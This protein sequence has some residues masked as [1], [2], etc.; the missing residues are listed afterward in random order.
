MKSLQ[1][2]LIVITLLTLLSLACSDKKEDSTLDLSGYLPENIAS[3]G[4]ERTSE[5][6]AYVGKS[7]WEYVNGGAELYHLYNFAQV[8]TADYRKGEIEII[9]DIYQFA[10]ADDAYGIYS[11]FRPP[12]A[13]IIQ[14][15]VEGF[16]APASLNFIKGE[17]FVRL[18]GFDESIESSLA[19]VNLAEEI[20]KTITG[21]NDLPSA[22]SLFPAKKKLPATGKYYAESF[23]GQKA[24]T[25]VY[26]QDYLIG[27]DSLT[28][29]LSQDE[30]GEKYLQWSEHAERID[31]K[32]PV[33][34]GLK[35]D[36]RQAFVFD[37]NFYGKVIVGLKKRKLVGIVKYDTEH[38]KFFAEWLNSLR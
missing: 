18:T 21:T 1:S 16:T 23:L 19:M 5:I 36:D 32:T 29:F 27:E 14:L 3:I 8:A 37:D 31:R 6:R 2:L 12:D 38:K 4:L 35:F 33:S 25:Q 13:T 22:F 11:M 10:T 9:V 17:Y 15:G 7:L 20:G 24:L 26:S 34:Q 28:L 30:L